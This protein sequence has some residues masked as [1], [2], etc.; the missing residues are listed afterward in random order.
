MS[1]KKNKQNETPDSEL[2]I[3]RELSWLDFNSRVLDEAFCPA[4]PLLERLKFIAIFSSNLDEFFMVRI[5][6]LRQLVKMEQNL[7]DPAG[8]RPADQLAAARR[9]IERLVKRQ[10][11]CLH[12]EILP[13]LERHGVRLSRPADLS[14]TQRAELTGY[15]TTQVLPV[16]TPLAVDQA[17]PFP[18][19]NSGA[20]E[21]AVSMKP[22]DRKK[23]VYAFVEVPDV[24]PRFI[25]VPGMQPGRTFVLLEDVIMDNLGALFSGCE[26]EE[27]F[28]FRVTRDMD[29]SVE[30][31]GAED[32]L[33][34]I[35]KKLLQRR[36]REPIR[37][38]VLTNTRG[39]LA[40]WLEQEFRL[41]EQFWY[42][43]RGPLHLKQFFELVGK[44]R[45]PE[46]LE[47]AWPAVEPAAFSEHNSVFDA[48]SAKGTIL[49][50]PPFHSFSPVVRLLQQAADD[51]DVLAIKQTLYRVSGNSPVVRSLQRAAE[52]G[53]QVTVVVELKARFD[54]GNNIA[55]ARLLEESGAHVVYGVA[56]L[57]VHS[58][59]L[60][61]VRREDGAI[62]RYVHL[63]TGNYNDK[64]AALYTDLGI[65]SSDPDLCFDVAN[66]F[67]VLTG[68]SSPPAEWRKI[69]ASPF[70]LR[71][72]AMRLI[73]REIANSTPDRPGR[74]IAKMNSLSDE[75]MIR[76]LHKAADAGV[77]IDL[78]VRGICCYKPRAGQE[79]VRII[80]I[81]D[82]YL[83][84]S[85]LFYFFNNGDEEY[86]LS[87]ADWMYR[88]LDK[89]VELLFP[90]E[91]EK[92]RGI[93]MR[94]LEFQLNDTDKL[95]R[96]QA[97]GSYTRSMAEHYTG[98]RS[99]YNSYRYLKELAG[100]E[101]RDVTG[102]ALKV[103][104]SPERPVPTFAEDDDDEFEDG[105]E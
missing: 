45:L 23:L 57:K 74:I 9:K 60:L 36:H 71:R 69:A 95:R 19:L 37:V 13:G 55:W 79:N 53:K 73:E 44:A 41:D 8:N 28:P 30:D 97:S 100:A 85:R 96:L 2:F 29:F 17:H 68:Y 26:I 63:S 90:I 25:E 78:I 66:L 67:N 92:I 16:L 39:P 43:V 15:F 34:S 77:E 76:L 105:G 70:D 24:L 101:M 22:A 61:V 5:A 84:H 11:S 86:Y 1:T 21:I 88:N 89:R 103:F 98:A 82:R 87:S 48:I 104:T 50:A 80:S 62:R 49:V 83:E 72:Q 46:L 75:K 64:T 20:I 102:E 59:A 27:F 6:G 10:Y 91:D 35:E 4:N 93:L 94:L 12:D 40:R 14:S 38:E 56:G 7:P 18:I 58:K 99:Q 47:P 81:V 31:E 54:E 3:S 52:N 32:L 51:P 42:A 33:Q 65:M